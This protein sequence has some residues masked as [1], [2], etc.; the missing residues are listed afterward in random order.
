MKLSRIFL[1]IGIS[2]IF[3]VFAGYSLYVFY[4]PPKYYLDQNNTCHQQFYCEN[5][6]ADCYHN[7][8]AAAEMG[9]P[10]YGAEPIPVYYSDARFAGE[11]NSTCYNGIINSQDYL[12]CLEDRDNC[13]IDFQKSTRR[14][15]HSRNSFYILTAIA[16]IAII[17]GA[18][19]ISVEGISSGLIGGGILTM[20]YAL[21][22]TSEYWLTL[23]KYVKLL[24]IF[25][26]LILLFYIGYTKF[27]K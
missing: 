6:T 15:A 4:E 9:Y 11:Y 16:M 13:N 8:T 27:K 1:A 10:A 3:A 7:K 23:G 2:I 26:V 17:A 12:Q 25:A 21:I 19:F 22:S 18:F 14:Y 5:M 24:A 20:L